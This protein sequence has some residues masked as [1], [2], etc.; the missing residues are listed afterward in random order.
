MVI[1]DLVRPLKIQHIVVL[2][3]SN[4][5]TEL[6]FKAGN[7][8][9]WKKY[10]DIHEHAAACLFRFGQ[11]LSPLITATIFSV[12][13]PWVEVNMVKVSFVLCFSDSW[14]PHLPR[15]IV[16]G[17][18]CKL[19]CCYSSLG[20]VPHTH[21]QIC[22]SSLKGPQWDLC[23][24]IGHFLR[25]PKA[26]SPLNSHENLIRASLVQQARRQESLGNDTAETLTLGEHTPQIN[27]EWPRSVSVTDWDLRVHVGKMFAADCAH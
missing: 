9:V 14:R 11:I 21:T 4:A 26:A 3:C 12:A 27:R 25:G 10:G 6:Q 7:R 22:S 16:E 13:L 5:P 24:S 15:D 20:L 18:S 1:S 8:W 2:K 23:C 19:N 17:R